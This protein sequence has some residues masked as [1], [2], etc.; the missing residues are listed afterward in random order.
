MVKDIEATVRPRAL[1]RAIC[2]ARLPAPAD[3]DDGRPDQVKQ[4]V[5]QGSQRGQQYEVQVL[6]DLAPMAIVAANLAPGHPKVP[7]DLAKRP[8]GAQ[9]STALVPVH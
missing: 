4:T 2:G 9:H 8:R 3:D 5:A 6:A 7:L 1:N